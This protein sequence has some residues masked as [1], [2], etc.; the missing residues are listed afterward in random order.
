MEIPKSRPKKKDV[1]RSVGKIHVLFSDK[2]SLP[3]EAALR[4]QIQSTLDWPETE[5]TTKAYLTRGFRELADQ[6]FGMRVPV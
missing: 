4:K 5:N 6:Q 2:P 3:Q 1:S